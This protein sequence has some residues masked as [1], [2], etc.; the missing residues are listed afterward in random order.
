MELI[1]PSSKNSITLRT[2]LCN[3]CGKLFLTSRYLTLHIQHVHI[4]EKKYHCDVC[5]KGFV[6]NYECKYH[7]KRVH[8]DAERTLVCETCGKTF[9]QLS[10]LRAHRKTHYDK[11]AFECPVCHEFTSNS[12]NNISAHV[13]RVHEGRKK[14]ERSGRGRPPDD[15]RRLA[16]N[17][18]GEEGASQSNSN[19]GQG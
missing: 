11:D 10:G 5:G 8:G 16:N 7:V 18:R 1:E 4:R 2:H 19:S 15:E 14:A 12:K 3:T 13:R 6:R 9:G 17:T